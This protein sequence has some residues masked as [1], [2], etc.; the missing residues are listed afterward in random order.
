MMWLGPLVNTRLAR[1]I[2]GKGVFAQ[3]AKIDSGPGVAQTHDAADRRF[4]GRL[5][6]EK[7]F[8]AGGR[9]RTGTLS[10]ELDFESSASTSSATPA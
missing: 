3:I 6:C 8:G 9:N 10:P 4:M 2:L 5:L 7:A 1:G